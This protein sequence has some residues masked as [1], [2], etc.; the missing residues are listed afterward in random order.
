VTTE[1]VTSAALRAGQLRAAL[2][3]HIAGRGTFRSPG[4]ETAFRTV[5]RHLFLPGTDLATAYAPQVVIIKRS[6]QGAALSSASSP[7]LVAAMLEQLAVRP[8]DQILEVGAGTG[9]NA[10]P[11]AELAGPGGHVTTIE[12]DED[13]AAAAQRSL[14]AAGYGHVRVVCGDGAAG[15]AEDAPYDRIIVT[16]GAWDLPA[17]WW[18]QLAPGGRIVV[19][20]RL[21]GSGLTRSVAFDRVSADRLVSTSALVC[22]FVPMRGGTAAS[23]RCLPL[24]AELSLHLD[25]G[26]DAGQAVLSAALDHPA[27]VRWTGV[28]VSDDDPSAAH[29]DLWLAAAEAGR[30]GR[31]DAGPGASGRL[32]APAR[33]W[34]GAAVHSGAAICWATVRPAGTDDEVGIAGYGRGSDKLTAAVADLVRR[35]DESRPLLPTITARPVGA[36][37]CE[38]VGVIINRPTARLTVTWDRAPGS[39][40]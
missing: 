10:A 25:P 2:A 1:S 34:S 8:G 33:R 7:N 11:L 19:P 4:V 12:I 23:G 27:P 15:Y 39:S 35:W 32:A 5:P 3:D 18:Q 31:A 20:V 29:L 17:A 28:M 24:T 37:S 6:D 30:F 26:D 14:A 40:R 21:H 36:P 9:F 13:L 38:Q 16:A 22:G